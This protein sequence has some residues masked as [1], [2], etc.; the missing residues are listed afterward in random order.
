[1]ILSGKFGKAA[2]ELIQELRPDGSQ[3]SQAR[4][5]VILSQKDVK[6]F[7]SKERGRIIG[8]AILRWH[9]LP[10]GRVGTVEDVIVSQ[11]HRGRGHGERLTEQ[12]ISFAKKK[13]MAYIDLTSRPERIAANKLYQKIGWRKRE[14]NVYRLYISP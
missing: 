2:N 13:R 11:K 8:M 3:V 1:M 12:I 9:D 14:T 5:R 4:W 10:V 6:V 7:V